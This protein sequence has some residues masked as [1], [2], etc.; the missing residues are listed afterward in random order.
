MKITKANIF[1]TLLS[2]QSTVRGIFSMTT[3]CICVNLC[4]CVCVSVRE[5]ETIFTKQFHK[6][7]ALQFLVCHFSLK[8]KIVHF[9]HCDSLS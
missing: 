9:V 1:Q 6:C 5:H 2:T 8:I 3:L 4:V 7:D